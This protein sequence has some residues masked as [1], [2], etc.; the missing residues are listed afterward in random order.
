MYTFLISHFFIH[1][2]FLETTHKK[3]PFMWMWNLYSHTNV[4]FFPRFY[5]FS[6]IAIFAS[7]SILPIACMQ[8]HYYFLLERKYAKCTHKKLPLSAQYGIID[9][10]C[11]ALVHKLLAIA[12][13]CYT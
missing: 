1:M 8:Y 12:K 10:D 4:T 2:R 5:Y 3:N 13:A 9:T 11:N 6:R 7:H